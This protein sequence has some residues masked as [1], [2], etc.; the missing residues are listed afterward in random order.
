MVNGSYYIGLRELVEDFARMLSRAPLNP[1]YR[2]REALCRWMFP[3]IKLYLRAK[4]G[5][6]ELPYDLWRRDLRRK[7]GINPLT[8]F[9]TD[10]APD[11]SIDVT[12][13]PTLAI[14]TTLANDER[15][16][17]ARIG[18]AIGQGIVLSH[19]YPAV[20]SFVLYT[21][22]ER[23]HQRWVERELQMNLWSR[24]K[25]KLVLREQRSPGGDT[26]D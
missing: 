1:H 7:S 23:E 25:V 11:F 20:I 2:S 26:P 14:L 16:V 6:Q 5:E 4:L 22:G 17:P 9:A 18:S 19:R 13:V 24:H 3:M 10:F 12:E 15:A 8:L 21:A